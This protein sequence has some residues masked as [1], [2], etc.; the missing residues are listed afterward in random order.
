[1]LVHPNVSTL[2]RRLTIAF[3][4][5][6]FDTPTARV[7]AVTAGRPSGMVATAKATARFSSSDTELPRASPIA[8][9][10]ATITPDNLARLCASPSSCFCKGVFSVS[11]S[12]RSP[13]IRPI[14]V[15]IP[16]AVTTSSPRPRVT[17]VFMKAI[18]VRS[19]RGALCAATMV[20]DFSDG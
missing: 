16:V 13:A 3:L 9:T 4:R 11:V 14:S 12:R 17:V 10:A 8:N 6:I 1:M 5:A 2:A 20:V 18:H 7:T 19:P 15:P